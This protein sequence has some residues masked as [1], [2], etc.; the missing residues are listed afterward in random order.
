MKENEMG[1]AINT[2]M[3]YVYKALVGNL[4]NKDT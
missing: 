3:K 1:G 2:S 4:K